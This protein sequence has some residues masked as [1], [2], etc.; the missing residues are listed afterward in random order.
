MKHY[1]HFFANGEWCKSTSSTRID[2]VNPAT[3]QLVGSVPDCSEADVEVA[4]QAARVAFASWS[5]APPAERADLLSKLRSRLEERADELARMVS[6]ELGMPFRMAQRMQVPLPLGD[7]DQVIRMVREFEFNGRIGHSLVLREPIGVVACITPWNYPL[8]QI[9]TKVAPALG[10]GC[11]VV[12]KP[13]ELVPSVAIALAEEIAACGFPPGVFNMVTGRGA[14]AGERLVAHPDVDMVSFTGSTAAGKAVAKV[15]ADTVKRVS[16][17][18]GGK[19]AAVL[20]DDADF[21][22]AVKNAV[23]FCYLNSGQTCAA[24]TRLLVPKRR[25]DEVARLA[26]QTAQSFV[27]GDPFDDKTRLGPLA[28]A[29]QRERVLGYIRRAE[30][31]SPLLTGGAESPE[32]LSRGF[33]VRPTV[34][35]PVAPQSELAQQE[36]FGPVLAVIPYEDE[37]EAVAIANGTVYGLSAAVWSADED[38]ALSFARRL[39][40]GQ[41]D[42]NGAPFNPAAPFGGYKQ[43][44]IGRELGLQGFEE[45]LETKAVQLKPSAPNPSA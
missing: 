33:F 34:F 12:L 20:L 14:T 11:T 17:E 29:A 39:R 30:A 27:L 16:L 19:S 36:V 21:P 6:S 7:L 38:R 42:V 41:V 37:E 22:V 2:V 25:F 15:A 23:N 13:S 40:A 35:G 4:V 45:F 24:L 28:S 26:V 10:A 5:V 43:S 31:E 1:E 9:M 3:E 18:L 8:H 44:G 32:G